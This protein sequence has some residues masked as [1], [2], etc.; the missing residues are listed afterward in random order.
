MIKYLLFDLDG[1]IIDPV[2]GITKSVKYALD[3]FGIFAKTEDLLDFIGPPLKVSFMNNFNMDEEQANL[4]I[5]KYR[6]RFSNIGIYENKLYDNMFEAIKTFKEN[7]Y[8]IGLATSK[9][10]IYSKKILDYYK[11]TPFFDV[12]VGSEMDGS[13][14]T[15]TEIIS[16]CLRQLNNPNLEEVIMIGDRKHDIIA[17]K[18]CNIKSV[19][20]LWGYQIGNELLENNATYIISNI[21]E[22]ENIIKNN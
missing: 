18:E 11:L 7:N 14:T 19:G 5:I 20:V 10:T 9:P 17:A 15:K 12:I 16:E 8:I 4:A 1:T 3:S 2:D 22:L 6:E 13:R 21:S